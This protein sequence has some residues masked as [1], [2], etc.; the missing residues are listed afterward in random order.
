MAPSRRR[1]RAEGA[2]RRQLARRRRA[3]V[4]AL[5]EIAEECPD[6]AVV[7]VGRRRAPIG[8]ARDGREEGDELR[9]I[10]LVGADRMRR[11]VLVEPQMV[12]E[13]SSCSF[14]MAGSVA[15]SSQTRGATTGRL[16]STPSRSSSA[17]SDIASLRSVFLRGTSRL[18]R[19]QRG[20]DAERDV[21]R[22]VVRGSA[23]DT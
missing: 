4:A 13:T 12:E 14:I 2:D 20:H 6:V 3:R 17:R 15:C 10:A 18:L 1:Y 9:Q 16:R 23:C 22:L 11:G 8:G 5:V 21:R 7:E 19:A